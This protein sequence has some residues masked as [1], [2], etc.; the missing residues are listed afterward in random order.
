MVEKKGSNRTLI[1]TTQI[2]AVGLGATLITSGIYLFHDVG[3]ERAYILDE[4]YT[5]NITMRDAEARW[6]SL[7]NRATLGGVLTG[8]GSALVVGVGAWWYL[9]RPS[10]KGPA[11]VAGTQVF[12]PWCDD[13]GCGLELGGAF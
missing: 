6:R 9:D 10:S 5:P 3:E 2:A 4:K 12:A 11:K 1:R 8:L 13:A 7:N